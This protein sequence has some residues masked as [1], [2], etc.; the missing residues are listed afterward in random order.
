MNFTRYMQ[1]DFNNY[2]LQEIVKL[3]LFLNS[4]SSEMPFYK[5]LSNPRFVF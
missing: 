5:Y 2:S 4:R 3:L 1:N